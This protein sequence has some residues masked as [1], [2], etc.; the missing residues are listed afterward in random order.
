MNREIDFS[1]FE[2]FVSENL[3][4]IEN[5]CKRAISVYYKSGKNIEYENEYLELFNNVVDKLRKNDFKVLRN[6]KQ[7]ANIKTYLRSI[8]SF[9]FIDTLRRKKTKKIPQNGAVKRGIILNNDKIE[10]VNGNS[11]PEKKVIENNMNENLKKIFEEAFK[12]L[13]PIDL[14]IIKMKFSFQGKEYPYCEIAK[15]LNIDVKNVYKR[16]YR[17]LNILK[18]S[19]KK[20]GV[21]Y[22]DYF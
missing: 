12:K 10:V 3:I 8:I 17:A 14:L 2:K 4:F 20:N 5:E 16:V 13:D 18:K 15:F 9:T 7:K 22:N 21:D 19:F 11:N 6:F 1:Y